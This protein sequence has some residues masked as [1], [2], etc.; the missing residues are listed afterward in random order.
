MSVLHIFLC[1]PTPVSYL[2]AGLG[3]TK[4]NQPQWLTEST[5][6]LHIPSVALRLHLYR[7][8]AYSIILI[9]FRF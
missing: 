1:V 6:L 9:W 2:D 5:R 3:K 4:L 7:K 8:K